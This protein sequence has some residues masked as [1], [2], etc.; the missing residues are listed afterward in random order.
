MGDQKLLREMVVVVGELSTQF[1]RAPLPST[2]AIWT[3]ILR[4]PVQLW[5]DHYARTWVFEDTRADRFSLFPVVKLAFFFHQQYLPDARVR[6][7]VIRTRL[8]PFE[9]L[10]RR[11]RSLTG[12]SS[13]QSGG[14]GWQLK[15][16][17]IRFLFH[18]TGG[19][20]YL[21]EI[22]RWE[23]LNKENAHLAPSIRREPAATGVGGAPSTE[24]TTR[25]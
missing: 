14:R 3:E 13:T 25:L 10:F 17:L 11:V 16:V 6:R 15:R 21:W 8:F 2:F 20:R 9:K 22:P 4:P 1:F 24:S 23:R 5:I 12:K 18:V 7:Q 19:L